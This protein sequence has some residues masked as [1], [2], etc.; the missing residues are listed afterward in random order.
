MCGCIKLYFGRDQNI[1]SYMDS[2]AIEHGAVRIDVEIFSGKDIATEVAVK[3][4]CDAERL[5]DAAEELS[6]R[7]LLFGDIVGMS[8]VECVESS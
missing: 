1:V 2:A 7:L 6:N 3:R 8:S 5:T 4:R